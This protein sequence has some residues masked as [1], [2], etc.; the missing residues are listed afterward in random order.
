M[1][2]TASICVLLIAVHWTRVGSVDSGEQDAAIGQHED[3]KIPISEHEYP[4]ENISTRP[5]YRGEGQ[6]ATPG[7]NS[8]ID[9]GFVPIKMYAQVCQIYYYY[10]IKKFYIVSNCLY[11]CLGFRRLS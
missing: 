7:P 3:E 10:F 6:W 9:L 1:L 5:D 11:T 2:S 8:G 4:K